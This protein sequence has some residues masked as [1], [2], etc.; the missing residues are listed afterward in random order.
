MKSCVYGPN[1][2]HNN[3]IINKSHRSNP[4]PQIG[5]RIFQSIYLVI[6]P[7]NYLTNLKQPHIHPKANAF[8]NAFA[9]VRRRRL[10]A[11]MY[12]V[13]GTIAKFAR[14][15]RG[16]GA[17]QRLCTMYDVGCTTRTTAVSAYGQR[18]CAA[19][20]VKTDDGCKSV[21]PKASAFAP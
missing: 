9:Y 2:P 7:L 8:E 3:H 20:R 10:A 4:I 15:A 12:E 21:W 13:R 14:F 18:G 5:K 6:H 1:N 17:W 11:P 16:G 19:R